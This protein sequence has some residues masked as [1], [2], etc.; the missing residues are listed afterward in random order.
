MFP[1]PPMTGRAVYWRWVLILALV[2]AAATPL[3]IILELMF[4]LCLIVAMFDEHRRRVR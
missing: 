3:G 1:E 4:M 2:L